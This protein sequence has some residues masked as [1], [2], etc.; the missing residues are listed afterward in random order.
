MNLAFIECQETNA[1]HVLCCMDL[2]NF[3]QVNDA[4]GHQAGDLL[5]KEIAT[6]FK[7]RIRSD[8]DILARIGGDEFALLLKN[9]SVRRAETIANQLI[10]SVKAIEFTFDNKTFDVGVSIGMMLVDKRYSSAKE[11]HSIA[12]SACYSAKN[13]G[14]NCVYVYKDGLHDS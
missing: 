3:K 14:K 5:L 12:D 9:C 7:Q 2:D 6:A 11:C 13:A 8:N 4:C 10:K 1:Q